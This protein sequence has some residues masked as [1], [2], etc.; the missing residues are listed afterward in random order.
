M[1]VLELRGVSHAYSG[2][3]VLRGVDLELEQGRIRGLV[4]QNGAGKSTLI[5]ILT[6][7][8]PLLDGRLCIDGEDATL[9]S[10]A[11]AQRAGIGVV[12]QD[13]QLFPQLSVGKNIFAVRASFPRKGPLRLIDWDRV[14]AEVEV[15]L[16][17]LGLH[18]PVRRRAG[19]LDAGE[20]KLVEIARTMMLKPR[21]L[22]LDEPTASLEARSSSRILDLLVRLR[23]EGVGVLIVS[24]RLEEIRRVSDRITVLRDGRVVADVPGATSQKEIVRAMLGDS[25]DRGTP[26]D[27]TWM[28]ERT[29]A[30]S[31]S[32]MSAG[33]A[34]PVE[35]KVGRGEILGLTGL[36]GSGA[37]HVLRMLGGARPLIGDVEVY[38]R[39]VGITSP[40]DAAAVGIGYIPEDRKREGLVPGMSVAANISLS[41]LGHVSRAGFLRP[42]AVR[43]RAEHYRDAFEI[44]C[45][46]TS[47]PV[48]TLSGGNQQKVLIA[49]WLSAG[50]RILVVAEP[51]H[52]VDVGGKAQIHDLIR[53][54]AGAGGAVVVFSS[55]AEELVGLC[56]RVAVFRHG[57]I[58]SLVAVDQAAAIA[59]GRPA[60][61]ALVGRLEG[62]IEATHLADAPLEAA[63][64]GR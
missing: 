15:S 32:G 56:H 62:I 33:G 11:D 63:H 21:F 5:R 49:K 54:F 10:P 53:E 50:V 44:K 36:V 27:R 58:V 25:A 59:S 14:E 55:E 45:R 52:G 60:D 40:T 6:G 20:Q 16:A 26:P 22:I 41:S 12:H 4:G 48:R 23:D 28:G 29:V 51:T 7:A 61:T 46:D 24:H 30:L 1:A 31:V 17:S 43:R 37:E 18:I 2:V 39:P 42:N 3:V 38:G 34:A 8:E 9:S 19:D 47:A 13:L 35:F 64:G 57:R